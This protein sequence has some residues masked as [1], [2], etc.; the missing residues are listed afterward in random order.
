[1]AQPTMPS[2]SPPA[3]DSSESLLYAETYAESGYPH[4]EWTRLRREDPVHFVDPERGRPYWAITRHA[5]IV[6][7]SRQPE[8]FTNWPRFKAGEGADEIA[9]VRTL[10]S[11]DPPDHRTY[12]QIVSKRFT[13]RALAKLREPIEA[14]TL[15]LMDGLAL[16]GDTCE[17]D[18][19]ER[20]AAPLPI[21]II[22]W[23]LGLPRRDWQRI[24]QLTNA[25]IGFADSEFQ[26]EGENFEDTLRRSRGEI[27]EYFA[28]LSA[29]RRKSPGD[30]LIS[31]LA[32]AEIDGEPLP[33]DEL[34]AYYLILVVAG[35]ETTRNAVSG[36]LLA[37]IENPEQ[38]S[39]L[40]ADPSLLPGAVEET[41]RWTSP[42]IHHARTAAEDV[43]LR[44]VPIKQG[45]TLALF[46]PSANRDEEIW[47]DPFSFRIDRP[48]N[49]HLALGVGEH[50]CLGA[51]L[52]RLEIELALRHL[53]QRIESMECSGPVERLASANV[54]GIKQLP[55]RLHLRSD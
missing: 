4:D 21:L 8:R 13:P 47:D 35:N 31:Q 37:F 30:D 20:V 1:M 14:V 51:H 40:R 41:L 25:L 18:F 46:Y 27:F 42:V 12:R 6:W 54:G 23:V 15:E 53:S 50:V 16:E 22:A 26:Q 3:G 29:E 5:D 52:A 48:R 9:A 28:G 39:R 2:R 32:C 45:D 33:E 10:S 36:G 34:L 24:F 7:I 43:A 17:L 44:G 49:P 11:M 19:V 38:W 55:V